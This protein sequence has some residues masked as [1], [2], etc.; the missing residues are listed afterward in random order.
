MS[1]PLGYRFASTYAGI[2]KQTDDD[3]AL[4]VSDQPAAAAAVFTKNVVAAAPVTVSEEHLRRSGGVCRAIV[5]NAGNANCAT[6]TMRKVARATARA[7]A[8][9][10]GIPTSQ[11]LLASTGSS[12]AAGRKT[13]RSR[14]ARLS[15]KPCARRSRASR[16]RHH[17]DRHVSQNRGRRSEDAAGRG[18]PGGYGQGRRHDPTN[19]ATM[20]SFILTDA[21]VEAATLR[22]MLKRAVD[23]S[24][25]CISVDGDTS[26]ND[27]VYLLANGASGVRLGRKDRALFEE[28]LGR[29]A[30]ELAV[31]I[32]TDGE[33]SR[34]LLAIEV[35]GAPTDKTASKLARAIANSPLVKTA[36][37]GADPNWGRILSS[38]GAS[39]VGL[40]PPR[41]TFR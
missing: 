41:W 8:K 22:G 30:E 7:A 35:R 26:T 23:R 25:N 13:D 11:V 9:R 3:L 36:L 15:Q 29:L 28:A 6:P 27:T 14:S 18:P 2:R 19:M 24:F 33:G 31:A 17:D 5:A 4:I 16:S 38:A 12:R 39:G 1:V 10:L 34:K 37:A 40:T 32:V 20:L 21:A